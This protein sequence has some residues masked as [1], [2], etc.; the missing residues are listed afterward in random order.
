M[1]RS[2]AIVTTAAGPD[3]AELHDR[4]PVIVEPA[5][6]PLWLGETAGDP[7]ALLGPS[8]AG[9][10]RT[11]PVGRRVGDPKNNDAELLERADCSAP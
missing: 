3:I 8:P 1:V 2:F 10:L 5:N 9:T 6:W 11:W 4:M 7:A